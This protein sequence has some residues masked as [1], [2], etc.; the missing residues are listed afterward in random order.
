[1][2]RGLLWSHIIISSFKRSPPLIA[3][4]TTTSCSLGMRSAHGSSRC[5]PRCSRWQD[6][7]ACCGPHQQGGPSRVVRMDQFSGRVSSVLPP[8]DVAWVSAA[9]ESRPSTAPPPAPSSGQALQGSE[10]VLNS[11]AS[12]CPHHDQTAIRAA[13]SCL[14][15]NLHK[16]RH[17]AK[18]PVAE[19]PAHNY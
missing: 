16:P 18:D 17:T 14:A 11:S 19:K 3:S 9:S 13:S 10:A 6:L 7:G 12:P 15:Q 4:P 2:P 5:G 8:G 1:M